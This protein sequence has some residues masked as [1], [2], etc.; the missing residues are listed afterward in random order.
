MKASYTPVDALKEHLLSGNKITILEAQSLF[1]VQ[2]LNTEISRLRKQ[3]FLAKRAKVPLARVIRRMNQF[4]TFMPPK[5]LPITEI[6]ISEWWLQI[7]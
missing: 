5:E 3:G 2:N 7:D 4:C 6:M 1:A